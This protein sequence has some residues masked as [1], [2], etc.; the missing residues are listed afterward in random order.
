MQHYVIKFASDRSVVFSGY[1][2]NKVGRHDIT[3]RLLKVALIIINQI[4]LNHLHNREKIHYHLKNEYF[5]AIHQ[6]VMTTVE[7]QPRRNV[8]LFE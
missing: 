4:Q 6:S 2:I 8:A 1:S 5:V 3:E 7:Y